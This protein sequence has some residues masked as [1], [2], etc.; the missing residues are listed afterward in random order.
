M[1]QAGHL[2]SLWL[3]RD[4]F[5]GPLDLRVP[6]E[7]WQ[8]DDSRLHQPVGFS[9]LSSDANATRRFSTASNTCQYPA[10][11]TPTKHHKPTPTPYH[12]RTSTTT[13]YHSGYTPHP[14]PNPTPKPHP[15][16][17]PHP[18]PKPTPPKCGAQYV[19]CPAL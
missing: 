4:A 7:L 16:P 18:V 3:W 9:I 12:H 15:T 10:K 6:L 5:C 2:H 11:P 14:K 17:Y 13:E 19:D 1:E 8:R